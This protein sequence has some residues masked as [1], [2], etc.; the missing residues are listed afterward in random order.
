[1]QAIN[2]KLGL[3][4]QIHYCCELGNGRARQAIARKNVGLGTLGGL[5]PQKPRL[6][7]YRGL[8]DQLIRK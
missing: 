4:S 3:A 2:P 6:A 5:G 1:M 8:F 7:E